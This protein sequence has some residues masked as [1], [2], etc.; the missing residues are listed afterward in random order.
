MNNFALI[1]NG[2]VTNIIVWDGVTYDPGT[3][4]IPPGDDGKGGVPAVPASGW[5]PPDGVVA[6]VIPDGES[7]AIGWLY[8][9][10]AFSAPPVPPL[11]ADQILA[12]NTSQSSALMATANAA[13]VGMSDAY[14]AGLLDEADTAIFKAW[15]AY[16]L[17]LSKIDL[18]KASPP[19]PTAP[20]A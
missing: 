11:T 8:D 6:V 2:V 17:A 18:T 10:A 15:A 5:S 12:A 4:E 3:P 19:W 14:V 13:T 7:V 20:A 16:K 9:G 1:E